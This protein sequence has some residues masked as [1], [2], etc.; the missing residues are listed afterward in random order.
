M[1]WV[2]GGRIFHQPQLLASTETM[3]PGLNNE[4][5]FRSR[6][7]TAGGDNG[8]SKEC[9]TG[10]RCAVRPAIERVVFAMRIH[11]LMT[12]YTIS[13]IVTRNNVAT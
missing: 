10:V 5:I 1:V 11:N 4:K 3:T 12:A 9:F 2:V 7:G 13:I 6:V 8:I